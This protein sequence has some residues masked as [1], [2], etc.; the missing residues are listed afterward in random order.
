MPVKPTESSSSIT[1]ELR[2]SDG[3]FTVGPDHKIKL[4]NAAAEKIF[5]NKSEQ[6]VVKKCYDVL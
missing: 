2:T 4:W 3:M 6:V 1:T 5:G